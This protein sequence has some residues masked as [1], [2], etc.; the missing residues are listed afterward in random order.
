MSCGRCQ[1]LMVRMEMEDAGGSSSVFP[2]WHCLICGDVIDA[3][4]EANRKAP[5]DPI[6]SRARPRGTY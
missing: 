6:K 2:G 3:G 5:Q 1:G 4:I